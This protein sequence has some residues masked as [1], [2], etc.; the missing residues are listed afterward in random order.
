[1]AQAYR[2]R[3]PADLLTTLLEAVHAARLVEHVAQHEEF[4]L[5]LKGTYLLTRTKGGAYLASLAV[6]LLKLAE[7][8]R[9]RASTAAVQ[10]LFGGLNQEMHSD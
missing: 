2:A 5:S 10:D 6:A 4:L 7:M 3:K 1:M 9:R 8:L